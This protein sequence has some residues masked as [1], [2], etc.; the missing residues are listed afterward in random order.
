MSLGFVLFV[1]DDVIFW[2]PNS[3]KDSYECFNQLELIWNLGEDF[4]GV[5]V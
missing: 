2:E 4:I 5:K 3:N 1:S